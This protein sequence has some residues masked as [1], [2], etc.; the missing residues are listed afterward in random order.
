MPYSR[1]PAF[2]W[3]L[4]VLALS[5]CYVSVQ[6][7]PQKYASSPTA[8]AQ[9]WPSTQTAPARQPGI[10]PVRR[11]T[12]DVVAARTPHR[13]QSAARLHSAVR[14]SNSQDVAPGSRRSDSR[15]I[16]V[17]P[18]ARPRPGPTLVLAEPSANPTCR[19]QL[20]SPDERFVY[21]KCGELISLVRQ[22]PTRFRGE[23][24]T[25]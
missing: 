13:Q 1:F 3:V 6:A 17:R 15:K 16:S 8:S 20:P 12:V 7:S 24:T 14:P 22:T 23:R 18:M 19:D 25:E 9:S 11:H 2:G 4:A 10:Q 21:A 5:G